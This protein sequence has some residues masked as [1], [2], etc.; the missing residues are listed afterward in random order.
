MA[1]LR[2]LVRIGVVLKPFNVVGHFLQKLD[3]KFEVLPTSGALSTAPN[4]SAVVEL[5]VAGIVTGVRQRATPCRNDTLAQPA[6]P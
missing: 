3:F 4:R 6:F 1:F 5:P 2:V